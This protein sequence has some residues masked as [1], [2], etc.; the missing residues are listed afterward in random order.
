MT[1]GLGLQSDA[2]A[3]RLFADLQSL[4]TED[5]DCCG[6]RCCAMMLAVIELWRILLCAV[7]A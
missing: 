3:W 5:Q 6:N 7:L 1:V 2:G 4:E